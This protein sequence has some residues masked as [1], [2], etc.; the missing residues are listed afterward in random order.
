VV[1]SGGDSAVLLSDLESDELVHKWS[2]DGL[3]HAVALSEVDDRPVVLAVTDSGESELRIWDAVG[4]EPVGHFLTGHT[5]RVSA[6]AA[7]AVGARTLAVT[8]SD[9]G[10][11][12][13][14]DLAEGRQI[15][16]PLGGDEGE[17]WSVAIMPMDGRCV[18]LTAGRGGVV[19]VW[20]PRV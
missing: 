5:E 14:W 17:V 13:V 19:R 18:V 1:V 8:G 15:G 6:L 7:A 16:A 10:T 4:G 12:R 9:D 2:V 3:V 11:A 20:D